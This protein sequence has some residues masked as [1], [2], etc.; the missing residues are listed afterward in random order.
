MSKNIGPRS[1]FRRVRKSVTRG[2]RKPG[3]KRRF[4]PPFWRR[5]L[6]LDPALRLVQIRLLLRAR[7]EILSILAGNSYFFSLPDLLCEIS[8]LGVAFPS[9]FSE[10]S[11]FFFPFWIA[12]DS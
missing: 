1:L 6:R 3:A 4:L 5:F 10:I 2:S 8:G 12:F 7:A 11:F 9:E